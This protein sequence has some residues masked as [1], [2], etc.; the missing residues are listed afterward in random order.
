M[1]VARRR[2]SS[3]VLSSVILGALLAMLTNA[4][5]AAAQEK[6]VQ[7]WALAPAGDKPNEPGS[8]PNL[9]YELARGA[10]LS[11]AVV[12]FNYS[13]VPLTF[14]VYSTDAFNE[15]GTGAF[16]LIGEENKPKA[17]GSWVDLDERGIKLPPHTSLRIPFNLHVPKKATP[18]DH[19]GAIVASVGT[20]ATDAQGHQVLLTR[21]TGTRLYVRVAGKATRGLRVENVKTTYHGGFGSLRGS[22]E[23][24]YSIRNTGNVRLG[25]DSTVLVTDVL[26][27][28]VA[29]TAPARIEDLLPGSVVHRSERFDG[30][31][32][33]V[34][35]KGSVSAQAVA[36]GR[37]GTRLT[38]HT[39]RAKRT[40]A[41]PWLLLGLGAL[42]EGARRAYL[43]RRAP[44][45]PARELLAAE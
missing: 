40:L 17:A 18:G 14:N 45:R 1:T 28:R 5:P 2:R 38:L 29:R 41:L 44:R 33:W 8:R 35:L 22:T 23:V 6:V 26:G 36:P 25:V 7:S 9:T 15:K 37:D 27:R 3:A 34:I 32:A 13:T 16:S 11:D 4:S 12:L 20:P 24:E 19:A 43:R 21:R 31:G 30:V 39:S 42:A 10:S